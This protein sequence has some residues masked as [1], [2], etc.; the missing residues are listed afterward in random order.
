MT[1]TI[2][3]QWAVSQPPHDP[4]CSRVVRAW[5]QVCCAPDHRHGCIYWRSAG[6]RVVAYTRITKL[7]IWRERQY[8]AAV[9]SYQWDLQ[10]SY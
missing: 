1:G 3:E 9:R 7:T 5:P 4:P 6:W 10:L 8:G 2:H